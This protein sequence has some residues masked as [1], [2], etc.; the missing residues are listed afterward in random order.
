MAQQKLRS[1]PTRKPPPSRDARAAIEFA[2]LP[3]FNWTN[4][5]WSRLHL[6]HVRLAS[7]FLHH[8]TRADLRDTIKRMRNEDGEM[9]ADTLERFVQTRDH[10]QSL[11]EL[12]DA[13]TSRTFLVLED[14]G[15][16]NEDHYTADGKWRGAP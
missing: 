5:D 1:R 3:L 14:L 7:T 9:V 10:L 2:K 8:N 6:V 4:E 12:L 11:I 15:L 13:A 16:H